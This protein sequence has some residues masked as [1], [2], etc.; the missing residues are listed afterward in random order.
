MQALALGVLLLHAIAAAPADEVVAR[1]RRTHL[2][3][4]RSRSAA[5]GSLPPA[6]ASQDRAGQDVSG[7]AVS[8]RGAS[9]GVTIASNCCIFRSGWRAANGKR[10]IPAT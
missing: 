4:A 10:S 2:R 5:A 9:A 6:Q 8:P 1:I 3:R 7:S